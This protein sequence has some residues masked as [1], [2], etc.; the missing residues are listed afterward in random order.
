M[1]KF[2]IKMTDWKEYLSSLY[3]NPKLPSSY[4]GPEKLYQIVKCH[5]RFKIGR[6]RIGKWLQE[7][8]AYSLTWGARRKYTRSR[9]IVAGIDSQWDMDLMDMVDLA[10]QN[11]GVKYVLVAIDIFSCFA[12]CQPIKTKKGE[13]VLQALKL[14]LSGTRK[15]NMIRTD[16]GQEFRS[17][18][19]NAYL[20][21]QNIHH[22]YALNTEIKA[23]Y[24]ERLIKTLK[25]KLFR[26]M[27]KNRTQRYIDILQDAVYSY[28]RTIHRSLG[29]PPANIAKENEGESRLQQYL[30]RLGTA[31]RSNK[32]RKGPG[33][34]TNIRLTRLY[35]CL[36]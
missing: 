5:G 19:V 4:L 32:L 12:H 3:F 28:N 11:D 8:E 31:K 13:D 2:V 33:R 16:R 17:K 34:S 1:F 15:P 24:A 22:F 23:N 25:H 6:H 29:K 9:V 26:Y 21:G 36:M 27:L 20:K 30:L 35:V 14:I 18:D 7:Q 10:K